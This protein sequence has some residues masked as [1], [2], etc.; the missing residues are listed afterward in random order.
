MKGSTPDDWR[1]GFLIEYYSDIV[2]PRMHKMAYQAVRDGRWKYIHY[3]EH[4]DAD[5]LYDLQRDPYE[6]RNL[7]KEPGSADSLKSMQGKLA[8][9]LRETAAAR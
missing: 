1:D 7:A 5:E 6:L 9:L 8:K 2:F 4:A 3:L